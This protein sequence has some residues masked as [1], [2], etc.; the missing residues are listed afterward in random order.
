EPAGVHFLVSCPAVQPDFDRAVT[1]LHSF[2]YPESLRRFRRILDR[3]PGCAMARWGIAMSVW[4][5]L[6]AP[7]SAAEL[8]AGAE[9]LRGAQAT[10][11]TPREALWI[12]AARAFFADADPEH[13][14]ARAV[15]YSRH[16]EALYAGDHD[17]AEAAVF[18]ALSL[19]AL[20]DPR[21]KSYANQYHAAAILNRVRERQPHHPGVLHYLIH[22][23][24]YPGLAHLALGAATEYADAA[25]DSAHAQHMPA[26][27]FT[28]L[29][30][31]ERAIASNRRATAAAADY[32][33]H[34]HLPGHY[35]EGFHSID[36]EIYAL[37]QAARD[38]E[39]RRLLQT[40]G[41]LGK[42]DVDNFK[43]AYAY[44]AAP[45][46][47]ALERRAWDEASRLQLAP[48]D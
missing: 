42:A 43:V 2:E 12:E 10:R 25:P 30:L 36:Y 15:A 9:A 14:R 26:H 47:Y 21:D 19:L 31:W 37:L 34:A 13:H 22:A 5:P 29:G 3:D 48:A 32:T 20:A 33:A 7:P 38:D 17:D 11:M 16:M 39:A 1:L 44:A 4:H 28:R 24:D 18:Y 45:A 46:R 27:I 41:D 40:L 35:D 6:W 8:A 23:Y